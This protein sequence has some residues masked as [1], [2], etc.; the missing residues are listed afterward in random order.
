GRIEG[1]GPT[2]LVAVFG[3]EPIDNA[4][5]HAA[6]AALAI[7]NA[8]ARARTTSSGSVVIGIDGGHHAVR[9]QGSTMNIAMDGKA[10]TWPILEDLVAVDRPGAIVVTEAVVPFVTRGF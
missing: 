5:S 9:R 8:A 6:L 4:P 3:L 2:G 1:S 7:H 10:A